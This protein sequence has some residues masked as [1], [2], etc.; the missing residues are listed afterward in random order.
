MPPAALPR[1]RSALALLLAGGFAAGLAPWVRES[2]QAAP[3]AAALA[4][5]LLLV[6]LLAWLVG[7]REAPAGAASAPVAL[8]LGLA[9][10]ALF[11]GFAEQ[12]REWSPPLVSSEARKALVQARGWLEARS[13]EER[14]QA[15]RL[16]FASY[17]LGFAPLFVPVVA[18]CGPDHTAY[19]RATILLFALCLGAALALFARREGQAGLPIPLPWLLLPLG[20]LVLFLPSL[21]TLKWHAASLVAVVGLLGLA[22]VWREPRA[23]GRVVACL[24]LLLGA[25]VLYHVNVCFLLLALVLPVRDALQRVRRPVLPGVLL[26]L[27]VALALGW[28]SWSAAVGHSAI[29]S[30]LAVEAG[31]STGVWRSMPTDELLRLL[32]G[33][34]LRYFAPPTLALALLGTGVALRRGWRQPASGLAL[35]SLLVPLALNLRYLNLGDPAWIS[36]MLIPLLWLTALGLQEA[37]G[38]LG[39]LLPRPLAAVA[40]A[41]GLAGLSVAEWT[42]FRRAQVGEW[43][44]LTPLPQVPAAQIAGVRRLLEREPPPPGTLLLLPHPFL[45]PPQGGFRH[46]VP[47]DELDPQ[48]RWWNAHE[49]RNAAALESIQRA[50]RAGH[51]RWERSLLFLP[52]P[53]TPESDPLPAR[54]QFLREL[55][56]Q[57]ESIE[58]PGR[59]GG[60]VIRVTRVVVVRMS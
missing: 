11:C 49:F 48:A 16:G 17:N 43:Y 22:T 47:L 8:L 26:V 59:P 9:A 50:V 14:S 23:S 3:L 27:S 4:A 46:E 35:L 44:E 28:L 13:P 51:P 15:T 55:G 41:L 53:A 19:H 18:A 36:W 5:L 45:L 38:T 57:V 2:H 52:A 20:A 1:L 54:L 40:L 39:A 58:V 31:H 34:P 33:V 6:P 12:E 37:A 60:P 32:L 10:A 7:P 42:H 21:R 30:R 29:F 24:L 56:A 25:V